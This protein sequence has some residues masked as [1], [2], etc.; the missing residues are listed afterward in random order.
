MPTRRPYMY[1]CGVPKDKCNGSLD[2]VNAGL[3]GP[4]KMHVSPESAFSCHKQYLIDLGYKQL[5]TRAFSPPDGGPVRVL[6]KQSRFGAT[7]RNGKEGTR[8]MSNAR[9]K[10]RSCKSGLF[11]SC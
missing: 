7:L 9:G 10:K 6:T 3:A 2:S 11:I 4:R 1:L 5:D 8:N